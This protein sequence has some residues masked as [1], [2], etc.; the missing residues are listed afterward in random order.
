LAARIDA[1]QGH[2]PE[3]EAALLGLHDPRAD[4]AAAAIATHA[5]DWK[6]VA[7]ALAAEAAVTIPPA[8]ALGPQQRQL[9]LRLASARERAG[10]AAGLAAMRAEQARMGSGPLADVFRLLTAPGVHSPDQIARADHIAALAAQVA[11][12]LK[13]VR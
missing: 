5:G 11:P 10:D 4:R 9:L 7:A 1:A 12:A 2:V 3:A 6:Q 8:G 13:A